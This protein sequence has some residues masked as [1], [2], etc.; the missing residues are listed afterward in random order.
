MGP[1][2]AWI[3][4][5][6]RPVGLL[7]ALAPR[8]AVVRGRGRRSRS[9]TRRTTS[10]VDHAR[11][12]PVV[13]DAADDD[14]HHRGA[15][16]AGAGRVERLRRGPRVRHG[17]G[18]GELPGPDRPDPRAGP[19]EEPGRPPRPADRHPR[20]EPGR[21]RRVGRATGGAR[22]PD[23][24]RGRPTASTS[25]GSTHAASARARPITCGDAV[26]AFRADRP[27]AGHPRGGGGP[28]R[29][30]R[31][32][33]PTSASPPRAIAWATTAAWRWPTTSR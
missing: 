19:G 9:P 17:R 11:P 5:R 3:R 24:P 22:L 16:G 30:R 1:L 2:L 10:A 4:M 13:T 7:V 18:A 29:R 23:H 27:G 25:S 14:H 32:P 8:R 6:P 21:P 28:A 31:E 33:S 26:P 15:A 20:D 12:E